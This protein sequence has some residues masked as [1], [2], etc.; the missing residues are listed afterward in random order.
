MIIFAGGTGTR[1]WPLSRK[2]LP[3]QFKE[4]FEGKSTLQ[5]M[6][7]RV[8]KPFGIENILISTNERYVAY[9]KEQIPQIPLT[10]IIAEPEKR[11][12]GPAVGYNLVHLRKQGYK[13]PVATLWADHLVKDVSNFVEVLKNAEKIVMKDPNKVVFVG[14]TPLYAE[15]NLGWINIGKKISDNIF[16]FKNWKY[17][18]EINECKKMFATK[19]WYWNTGYFIYDLDNMIS[20]YEKFEPEMYKKLVKIEKNIGTINETETVKKIYPTLPK[21]SFDHAI[22]EKIEDKNALVVTSNMGWSDPGTLYAWKR[23]VTIHEDD[24]LLSGLNYVHQTRDTL[25]YNED[26]NKLVTGVGLEGMIIINTKDVLL[27][28]PKDKVLNISEVVEKL[29]ELETFK[30]FT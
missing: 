14:E 21:K 9:V 19:K 24:N 3:K 20:L 27:V 15:N 11:D 13:G 18:P 16:E 2:A 7:D 30:G 25:I 6:V 17:K 29:G 26:L 12:V 22:A 1:L 8:Q 28:I 4:M 23:A 10:N 5:L